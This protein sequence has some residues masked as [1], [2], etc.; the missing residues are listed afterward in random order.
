MGVRH[1]GDASDAC[2][3]DGDALLSDRAGLVLAVHGAD[4]A[5][6]LFWGDNGII[7][8]A[9]AGWRGLLDGVLEALVERMRAAGAQTVSAVL[10]PCIHVECYEFGLADLRIVIARLG[11]QVAGLT[12]RGRPALDLVAAVAAALAGVD[13]LLETSPS[14]CTSC[15][16]DLYSWRARQDTGRLA[17]LIWR[18][19]P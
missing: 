14:R 17:G 3:Q 15:H 19:E 8:A 16:D 10:G 1:V 5:P 12:S 9:H 18:E 7:G 13:V 11:P 2:G 4:C 6:V